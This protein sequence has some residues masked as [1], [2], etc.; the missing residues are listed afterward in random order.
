MRFS[1][2][3]F[4]IHYSAIRQSAVQFR[5]HMRV[6][7]GDALTK[8]TREKVCPVRKVSEDRWGDGPLAKPPIASAN[9]VWDSKGKTAISSVWQTDLRHVWSLRGCLYTNC[10]CCP[11]AIQHQDHP[12]RDRGDAIIAKVWL[13]GRSYAVAIERRKKVEDTPDDFYETTV[14]DKIKDSKLDEWLGC[15]PNRLNGTALPPVGRT[16]RLG[17]QSRFARA[18]CRSASVMWGGSLPACSAGA[19]FR[20]P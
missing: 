11:A 6:L 17:E 13:I 3:D 10:L 5:N 4:A 14:V 9:R 19:E 18:Q 1:P 20:A 8:H 2:L 12:H 7:T 15:L 16:V